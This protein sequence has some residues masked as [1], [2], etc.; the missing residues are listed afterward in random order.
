VD[1]REGRRG[2]A[3]NVREVERIGPEGRKGRRPVEK[4]LGWTLAARRV[5]LG[6]EGRERRAGMQL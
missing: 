1:L 2:E 6:Q 4:C 3:G 5:R